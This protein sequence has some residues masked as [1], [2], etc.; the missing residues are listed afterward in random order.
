VA[1]PQSVAATPTM[2][3]ELTGESSDSD[4]YGDDAIDDHEEGSDEDE[5]ENGVVFT[6]TPTSS[7]VTTSTP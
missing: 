3:E 4:E 6:D 7:R 5:G 1:A 2:Y